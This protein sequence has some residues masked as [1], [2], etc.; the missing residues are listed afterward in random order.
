MLLDVMAVAAFNT[1]VLGRAAPL[2]L[3]THMQVEIRKYKKDLEDSG[4]CYHLPRGGGG[5]GQ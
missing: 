1:T 5:G 3:W 2:L 4:K